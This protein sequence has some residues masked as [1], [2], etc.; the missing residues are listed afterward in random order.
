MEVLK[1]FSQG[2]KKKKEGEGSR[3]NLAAETGLGGC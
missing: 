1:L 2:H 3:V